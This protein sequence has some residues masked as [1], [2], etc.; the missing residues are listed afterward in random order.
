MPTQEYKKKKYIRPERQTTPKYDWN[1]A[2]GVKDG[3]EK[4]EVAPWSQYAEVEEE[5]KYIRPE[6]QAKQKYDW[7]EAAGVKDVEEKDRKSVV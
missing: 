4:K 5:K 1:E 2:A 7:N 3:E 6:S